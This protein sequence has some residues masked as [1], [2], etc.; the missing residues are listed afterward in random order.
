MRTSPN[1]KDEAQAGNN[2]GSWYAAQLA[3]YAFFIGDE[4]LARKTAEA[5][6]DRIAWQVEA[7]GKQPQELQRTRALG[8][9]AFNLVA[10]MTLAE[11]GKQVGVDLYGYQTKDGRGIRRALDYLAPYADASREWPH[12]QINEMA[13]AR[14][15]LAYLLRR[16]SIAYREPKYEELLETHL[17]DDAANQQWRLLWPR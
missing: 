10:L 3:C 9:S 12:Q 5:A 17:A 15:D 8:Y 13:G 14:R 6:R 11:A 7:D 4:E 16:A 2:H 1:G